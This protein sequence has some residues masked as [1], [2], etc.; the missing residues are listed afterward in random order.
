VG[1]VMGTLLQA[2]NTITVNSRPQRPS[3][4]R[5]ATPEP[6][7]HRVIALFISTDNMSSSNLIDNDSHLIYNP[8]NIH[9]P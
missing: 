8:T 3:P 4:L 6:R 5:A 9:T 2:A 1:G 7:R